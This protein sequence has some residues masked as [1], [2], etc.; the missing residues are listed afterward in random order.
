MARQECK[1]PTDSPAI[2]EGTRRVRYTVDMGYEPHPNLK[3]LPEDTVV[4]RYM[5]FVKLVGLLE[6]R[7]LWFA[8]ADLLDDPCEGRLTDPELKHL[9]AQEPVVYE[10]STRSFER[11]RTQNFVNCWQAGTCESTAMWEL[12]SA[13]PGS[14]AIRSTV[15]GLKEAVANAGQ[16]IYIGEVQYVDWGRDA[17]WPNNVIGICV[18]KDQS[19]RHESEVRLVVWAPDLGQRGDSRKPTGLFPGDLVDLRGVANDIVDTLKALYPTWD[20]PNDNLRSICLQAVVSWRERDRFRRTAPGVDI[21]V[22]LTRLID[23]VV[24]GPK[25]PRWVVGL[26][27]QVM[28][29]YAI[30]RCVRQSELKSIG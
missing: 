6:R 17:T 30:P 7:C 21:T 19:Y 14:V 12:Y 10:S 15:R 24:V 26:V 29:R 20:I 13:G 9:R 5:D 23:E 3:P 27:K 25:D 4:W 2:L 16:T 28:A 8:R 18:R 22:D 11:G 1:F